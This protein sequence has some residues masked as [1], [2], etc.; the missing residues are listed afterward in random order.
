MTLDALAFRNLITN[1]LAGSVPGK[2]EM[3]AIR[4][5]LKN[6]AT[7]LRLNTLTSHRRR[8]VET[9][10]RLLKLVAGPR[11]HA[12]ASTKKTCWFCNGSGTMDEYVKSL[13]VPLT[14]ED[15]D[16]P[17]CLVCWEPA[18]VS[19]YASRPRNRVQY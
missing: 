19:W 11:S 17:E 4:Q 10:S 9:T 16:D 14:N 2:R 5:V 1:V 8:P 6:K 7:A 3:A 12:P 13:Q 18:Q 15:D